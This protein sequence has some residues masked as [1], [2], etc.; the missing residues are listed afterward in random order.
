MHRHYLDLFMQDNI[1]IHGIIR[2]QYLAATE[3]ARTRNSNPT[4]ALTLDTMKQND[5][6]QIH[7]YNNTK[8][9]T[10]LPKLASANE[11]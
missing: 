6:T 2:E 3:L 1:T 9:T 7:T 11:Q 10:E 4:S 5:I 8:K